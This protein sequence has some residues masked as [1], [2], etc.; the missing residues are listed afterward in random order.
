MEDNFNIDEAIRNFDISSEHLNREA[1]IL[2]Q[3][4][5]KALSDHRRSE[6]MKHRQFAT[7]LRELKE[8]RG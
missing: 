6:A 5:M 4:G 2:G 8:R 7:W 3:D 1:D